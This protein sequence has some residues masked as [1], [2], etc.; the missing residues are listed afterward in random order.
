M[1]LAFRTHRTTPAVVTFYHDVEQDGDG[2]AHLER[3][4]SSWKL[5]R[6]DY[7]RTTV[8]ALLLWFTPV[9]LLFGTATF[10]LRILDANEAGRW[11]VLGP[12]TL[13]AAA[14]GLACAPVAWF[15]GM[16]ATEHARIVSLMRGVRPVVRSRVG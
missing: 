15:L 5:D 3:S 13:L 8:L 1:N 11:A 9:S 2:D 12:L 14:Y 10:A 4:A 6:W 16:S 7:V